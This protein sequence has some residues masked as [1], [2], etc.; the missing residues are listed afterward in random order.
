M[1]NTEGNDVAKPLS[2]GQKNKINR[3]ASKMSMH[4]LTSVRSNRS[5]KIDLNN[6]DENKLEP[7]FL[8]SP[9]SLEAC[10]K[11]GILPEELIHRP[12]SFFQND[13]GAKQLPDRVVELR[14]QTYNRSREEKLKT[15]MDTYKA[16]CAP[17]EEKSYGSDNT[18]RSMTIE[19]EEAKLMEQIHKE[20]EFQ[21]KRQK[22]EVE[23]MLLLEIRAQRLQEKAAAKAAEQAARAAEF[24]AVKAAKDA[25][26]QQQKAAMEAKKR[27][28][29]VEEAARQKRLA[30]EM[31]Q[32]ELANKKKREREEKERREAAEA[33]EA[34]MR[35]KQR[36]LKE[37]QVRPVEISRSSHPPPSRLPPPPSTLNP[38]A[39]TLNLQPSTPCYPAY[40][41]RHMQEA[42]NQEQ[43][44]LAEERKEIMD[45][46]DAARLAARAEQRRQMV[47]L[48]AL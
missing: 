27:Q 46:K 1:A 48:P 37:K 32:Q 33:R 5:V 31:M 30:D 15:V 36:E 14:F 24:A 39:G 21:R 11:E 42:Y 45:K 2:P 8:T 40:A 17:K 19:E 22:E 25:E 28:D 35:K 10:K 43:Q 44:K 6:F 26:W 38:D 3:S 29:E 12:P 16:L 4:S 47:I 41:A 34:E 18:P 9:R 7:P 23:T 20:M 13:R